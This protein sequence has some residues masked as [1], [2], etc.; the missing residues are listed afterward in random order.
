MERSAR[1]L[2]QGPPGVEEQLQQQEEGAGA[3]AGEVGG[4]GRAA[5]PG[6]RVRCWPVFSH[7]QV[8]RTKWH[9]LIYI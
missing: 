2:Q 6:P 9:D 4:L 3:A 5:E 1:P 7:L 8:K